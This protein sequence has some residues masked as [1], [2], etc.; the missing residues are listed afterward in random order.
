MADIIISE[1]AFRIKGDY[2]KDIPISP[3]V[4]LE[5][6]KDGDP[7]PFFIT[8]PIGQ[9]GG[10]TV[11]RTVPYDLAEMQAVVD[12]VMEK[13]PVGVKGHP[14][15]EELGS[16]FDLPPI[17][18]IGAKIAEDG[19]V[20][21]KAYVHPYATDVRDYLRAAAATN[22]KVGISI[23]GKADMVVKTGRFINMNLKRIDLVDPNRV[24]IKEAAAVPVITKE[25][26][27]SEEEKP[28]MGAETH[29]VLFQEYR[30]TIDSKQNQI[31]ALQQLVDASKGDH[32]VVTAIQEMAGEGTDIVK[33]VRDLIEERNELRTENF[34]TVV[35]EVIS[36][37]VDVEGARPN[38][39]RML[40]KDLTSKKEVKKAIEGLLEEEDVQEMIQNYVTKA[41][42]PPA[43][44]GGRDN[45]GQAHRVKIEDTPENREAARGLFGF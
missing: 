27:D 26:E 7:S 40:P 28:I 21:G 13:H 24:G 37:M 23:W 43:A 1:M 32:T 6:L 2:P 38:I 41:S 30:T 18:W 45:R 16:T 11:N 42:G 25:M 5:A 36:E 19:R 8:L 39:R 4:D 10:T 14:T 35:D 29:E 34:K 15:D 44:V 31:V 12:Q 17:R 20:W 22:S 33:F 9:V 3:T